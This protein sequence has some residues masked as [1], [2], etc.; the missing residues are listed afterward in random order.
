MS[1]AGP[2]GRVWRASPQAR[3]ELEAKFALL[4]WAARE[5]GLRLSP[6][7]RLIAIIRQSGGAK[8]RREG[9]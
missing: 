7:L 9:K 1:G 2:I 5:P 6:E 8:R 3:K 4:R